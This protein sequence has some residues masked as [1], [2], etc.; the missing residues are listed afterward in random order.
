MKTL[1]ALSAL[2][3]LA[4]LAQP[5]QAEDFGE[6]RPRNHELVLT[7]TNTSGMPISPGVLYVTRGSVNPVALGSMASQ[8]F[9]TLCHTGA[10][11]ARAA[12]LQRDPM[13]EARS[14]MATS[15]PILPGQS[16]SVTLPAYL[17]EAGNLQFEAMYG[18]SV[19]VCAVARLNANAAQEV[20]RGMEAVAYARDNVVNS[21]G[22]SAP[23]KNSPSQVCTEAS[24]VACL[25]DLSA[26]VANPAMI[27]AFPGY[28]PSV[29]SML[30]QKYPAAD[31]QSLLIPA[32]GALQLELTRK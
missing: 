24:A 32:S 16:L 26:P 5:A 12:E 23:A 17:L 13:V 21:G 9:V 10:N 30:E 20:S 8:G 11:A 15:S 22:F 14:V 27:K 19:D 7:I 18:K 4:A 1:F 3:S 25:R 2:V 28:L 6:Y 29:L 31:V